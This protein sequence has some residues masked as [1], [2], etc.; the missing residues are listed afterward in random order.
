MEIQEIQPYVG[1]LTIEQKELL[2]GKLYDDDS[3]FNPI[4]DS[5]E[6]WVIS[7]EE[8]TLCTNPEFKWVI[9]LPLI[10]YTPKPDDDWTEL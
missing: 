5:N 8:I 4:M 7:V 3:Y 9:E 10:E 2:V 1:L 6:Q